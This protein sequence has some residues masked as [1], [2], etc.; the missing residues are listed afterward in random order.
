[1][2]DQQLKG[3]L[4]DEQIADFKAKHG[5][6]IEAKFEGSVG[7]F[8]RADRQVMRM[9]MPFLNT[10][11]IKYM[12]IIIENCWLAGDE[13]MKTD[14]DAFFALTDAV[15]DITAKKSAEIKKH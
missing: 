2:A 6:V 9:A 1:M 12:E 15:P 7:Y 4:T 14:D 8:K 3:Q 11:R 5:E 10:D 13:K